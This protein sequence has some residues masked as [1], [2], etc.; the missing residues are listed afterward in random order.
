MH[1][2]KN[3]PSCNH[4]S[5]IAFD[6]CPHCGLIIKRYVEK[7]AEREKRDTRLE[8]VRQRKELEEK[9]RKI[10]DER[11]QQ[12]E[13][14]SFIA[15]QTKYNGFEPTKSA[16]PAEYIEDKYPG[17][18]IIVL[19][20]KGVA[21]IPALCSVI[22]ILIALFKTPYGFTFL[23]ATISKFIGI[24]FLSVVSLCWGVI[25]WSAA[26]SI[27]IFIDMEKNQRKILKALSPT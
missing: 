25:L 22:I 24:M 11:Y 26:E 3:C 13:E 7:T 14:A 15:S 8:E 2:T 16:P 23:E 19:L 4:V 12:K 17:M 1:E 20:T 18:A 5:E 21:C 10:A 9:R 27:Q 6:A